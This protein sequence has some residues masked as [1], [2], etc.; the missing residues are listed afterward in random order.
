M[1][2]V[3]KLLRNNEENK[4][5]NQPMFKKRK[6]SVS[7]KCPQL[8]VLGGPLTTCSQDPMTGFFRTG[9]CEA[10]DRDYGK[11]FVCAR[12]T[13]RFLE[14]SKFKGNDLTTPRPEFN[15]TGLREGD[16]WC[17]CADRWLEAFDAGLAPEVVL[18]ATNQK[19]LTTIDL[20]SLKKH[21]VDIN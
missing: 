2:V 16:Q 20:S 5:F 4:V 21:A 7:N 13:H 17:L 9:C 11:H 18:E 14:F 12:M 19:V 10:D 8:N 15:F 1:L 6:Y 3:Q